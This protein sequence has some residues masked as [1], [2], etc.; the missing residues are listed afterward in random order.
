[1]KRI[2]SLI[3]LTSCL[4]IIIAGCSS[5]KESG[6]D[7]K[8]TGVTQSERADSKYYI[9]PD[10]LNTVEDTIEYVLNAAMI[11]DRYKDN[12]GL[13][14]NEFAYLTDETSY[15]EYLKFGQ[16]SY[17]RIDWVNKIVVN[18]ME[19]HEHDS[20]TANVKVFLEYTNGDTTSIE[21]D[22]VIYFSDGRWI[23]PTVSVIKNQ[24]EYEALIRAAEEASQWED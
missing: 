3:L 8:P 7:D 6:T 11:R 2:Y 13:Y 17:E 19:L 14:E 21:D 23:K 16:I 18:Y 12:S 10:E 1:M 4:L 22:I 5:E 20:A 15:D 24:L 9:P